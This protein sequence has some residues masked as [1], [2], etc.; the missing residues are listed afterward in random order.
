MIGE[1]AQGLGSTSANTARLN[2][3]YSKGYAG[4][5]GWSVFPENTGDG[6]PTDFAA[7][8]TFNGQHSDIGPQ[9]P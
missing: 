5:W 9:T 6:I 3:W 7:L 2:Q 1:F 8:T 4:A